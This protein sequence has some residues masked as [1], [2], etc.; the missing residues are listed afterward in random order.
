MRGLAEAVRVL[1]R[2]RRLAAPGIRGVAILGLAAG[3]DARALEGRAAL[4]HPDSESRTLVRWE[5]GAPHVEVKVQV[6]SLVEVIPGLVV[7]EGGLLGLAELE[8]A[9]GEIAGYVG[10]HLSVVVE[11]AAVSFDGGAVTFVEPDGRRSSDG[12]QWVRVVSSGFGPGSLPAGMPALQVEMD[13]FLAT[14]PGHL[15]TL[16]VRWPDALP[17][18]AVLSAGVSSWS[19][20]PGPSLTLGQLQDGGLSGLLGVGWLSLGLLLASRTG[21]GRGS[22][23]L[24]PWLVGVGLASGV[25]LLLPGLAGGVL[26][27]RTAGLGA[28]IMAV[29]LGLDG[30]LDRDRPRIALEALAAGLVTGVAASQH[31]EL[32]PSA[33]EPG[34]AR[35][36]FL[37]GLLTTTTIAGGLLALVARGRGRALAGAIAVAGLLVFVLRA[38]GSVAPGV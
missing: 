2:S 37:L 24:L 21:S 16:V 3:G 35:L 15:D 36:A 34:F 25:E 23:L 9:T 17:D 28:A 19:G 20:T 32:L 30:A 12:W 26:Q 6:A 11:G 18:V 29:Y 38:L 8:A 31:P 33:L 13:L 22:R 1:V 7:E 10:D 14:S 27:A 4:V 5:D